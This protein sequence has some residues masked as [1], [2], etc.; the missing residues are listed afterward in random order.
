[1]CTIVHRHNKLISVDNAVSV[2]S[3]H[4]SLSVAAGTECLTCVDNSYGQ[5][6]YHGDKELVTMQWM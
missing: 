6:G 2:I 1:M 3:V 4:M 5:L